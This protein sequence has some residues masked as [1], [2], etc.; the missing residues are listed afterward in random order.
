MYITANSLY[1]DTVNFFKTQWLTIFV[2]IFVSS[3]ITAILD[4]F[5]APTSNILMFFHESKKDQYYSLFEFIQTLTPY[6]Q[7][8]LLLF[9]IIKLISSLIGNTVL[10]GILITFMQY[11]SFKNENLFLQLKPT[12]LF[13]FLNLFALILV[14]TVIIQIGLISLVLPGIILVILLSLSPI[15]LIVNNT[16]II[17]SIASSI[18]ITLCHAKIV[19]PAVIL[20][21]FLKFIVLVVLSDIKVIPEFMLLLS[22]NIIINFISSIL[23]IYLFRFHML[24]SA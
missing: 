20:W 17:Q 15:V 12:N 1:R 22:L 11:I 21:L 8:Q 24:L 5:F 4:N 18:K 19:F 3:I 9:S 7:K 6:Q 14:N 23:V 2:I 13:L 10:I 16:T